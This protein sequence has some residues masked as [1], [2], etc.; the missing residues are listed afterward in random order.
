MKS[1]GKAVSRLLSWIIV[2]L[3]LLGLAM[4]FG[5]RPVKA[6]S[7]TLADL[8]L[9][10]PFNYRMEAFKPKFNLEDYQLFEK[11]FLHA[12]LFENR[13]IL[14]RSYFANYSKSFTLIDKRS[15]DFYTLHLQVLSYLVLEDKDKIESGIPFYL[16]FIQNSQ[17]QALAF[18]H[19]SE[20]Y[21]FPLYGVLCE[22]DGSLIKEWELSKKPNLSTYSYFTLYQELASDLT[23]SGMQAFNKPLSALF[24]AWM[25]GT[26]L[27]EQNIQTS[28][29]NPYTWDLLGVPKERDDLMAYCSEQYLM[30]E[31][32]YSWN[33]DDSLQALQCIQILFQDKRELSQTTFTFDRSY[34]VH[35][36]NETMVYLPLLQVVTRQGKGSSGAALSGL[37]DAQGRWNF[38]IQGNFYFSDQTYLRSPFLY[39]TLFSGYPASDSS[40][41][42]YL[43]TL[44]LALYQ[45][46]DSSCLPMIVLSHAIA[47]YEAN[48]YK[49]TAH[50]ADL[51]L[52]EQT[53]APV[54]RGKHAHLYPDAEVF[55]KQFAENTEVQSDTLEYSKED[56]DQLVHLFLNS[57]NK[58]DNELAS[59]DFTL[60]KS[61]RLLDQKTKQS[62]RFLP[63]FNLTVKFK[64]HSSF[65]FFSNSALQLPDKTWLIYTGY[66]SLCFKSG[67]VSDL[68]SWPSMSMYLS[69][70]YLS[71]LLHY[72]YLLRK[73]ITNE[74]LRDFTFLFGAMSWSK[75]DQ[76]TRVMPYP[77]L[78][79]TTLSSANMVVTA[80]P[81]KVQTGANYYIDMRLTKNLEKGEW[82]KIKFPKA[83]VFPS[84][85]GTKPPGDHLPEYMELDYENNIISLTLMKKLFIKEYED[86]WIRITI[87]DVYGFKNPHLSGAYYF[88]FSTSAEIEWQK[89]DSVLFVE[90]R[91]GVPEGIPEVNTVPSIAGQN[92][93]YTIAFNVGEGGW[94]KQGE[95]LIRLRFP[96]DT[97][98]T[99][100]QIPGEMIL[101]NGVPLSV[102]PSPRGQNLIFNTPVEVE[103]S[104][105]VVIQID[106]KAGIINPAQAGDYTIEVS[107]MPADPEWVASKAFTISQSFAMKVKPRK[108]GSSASY[109]FT[110]EIEK[111]LESSDWIKLGFPQ[112]TII[113]PPIPEQEPERTLRLKRFNEIIVIGLSPCGPC[114]TLPKI[115]YYPDGSM[116]SIQVY[117]PI[118]IDPSLPGY[119]IISIVCP[120]ECGFKTPAKE[121]FYEYRVST[122]RETKEIST[123]FEIVQSQIGVP[124]GVPQVMVDPPSA[125]TQAGYK[126]IFNVG[127]GGW[128]KAHRDFIRLRFPKGT[129]WAVSPDKFKP[130]WIKINGKPL[131]AN[132]NLSSE[133]LSLLVPMDIEDSERVVV[134][135]SEALGITNPPIAGEYQ[136]E[137]ATSADAWA[138]SEAYTI[139][140]E[141]EED[142]IKIVSFMIDPH[143]PYAHVISDYQIRIRFSDTLP[144]KEGDQVQI[145]LGHQGLFLTK[146]ISD[147]KDMKGLSLLLR[148]IPNPDPGEYTLK[149]TLLEE[150]ASYTYRILH[151]IPTSRIILEGGKKGKN[152]W[153]LEPPKIS[154]EVSDPEAK[155]VFWWNDDKPKPTNVSYQTQYPLPRVLDGGQFKAKLWY[156][157]YT[158]HGE[159]EPKFEEIWVDTVLPEI[160]IEQP[161]S[162]NLLTRE[163]ELEI[164]GRDTLVKTSIYGKEVLIYDTHLLK[165]NG[166][167]VDKDP[168]DGSFSHQLLLE[169][170]ANLILIEAEDEAGNRLTREYKVELDTTPPDIQIESPKAMQTVVNREKKVLIK[171]RLDDPGAELLIQGKIVD[172]AEDGQFEHAY[173]VS[174]GLNTISLMASDKVGNIQKKELQFWFGHTI[175]M[176]IGNKEASNNGIKKQLLLA[177]FIQNGRTLV[178]FRFIGEELGAR[179]DF[180]FHPT[181]RLVHTVSYQLEEDLIVLTIGSKTAQVNGKAVGL[182]V[183][184]Q[185]IQ[186]TT[187]VPIR[188]IAE[189]LGCEVL[190][191]APEQRISISYPR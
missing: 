165:I 88:E 132:A 188:F 3:I 139:T 42:H 10:L 150:S 131:S 102:R 168:N 181:S 95:A 116:K 35:H 146:T 184:P 27:S 162:Q 113:D 141:L 83:C 114:P 21:D 149:V 29:P 48:T 73:P 97:V 69:E 31:T 56:L 133:T 120:E 183:A 76:L 121:G 65:P 126:V 19:R 140:G 41:V 22:S 177:P 178:P 34:L 164:S 171:G 63:S 37:K 71:Y 55:A 109:N 89:S 62:Y 98:F 43:T 30:E 74:E 85:E 14:K 80:K 28:N 185:I 44:G 137:V 32:V 128:L 189:N 104:E 47:L 112:G 17:G 90:S 11:V 51:A 160:I 57:V 142:R 45:Q 82:I 186:G 1:F 153:W 110:F 130:E 7:S 118:K 100:N 72:S 46:I 66:G 145:D 50:T 127:R 61:F 180:T 175:L 173:I 151:P 94:L 75:F 152:N 148:K 38:W 13:Y 96:K 190:W 147:P 5:P 23:N 64:N 155:V 129:L 87:P 18:I 125:Y 79:K 122:Q 15:N 39:H 6:Q 191:S 91:I 93:S 9:D 60:H 108:I 25:W 106:A 163:K 40:Y 174:T 136:V 134:E 33:E 154:F 144:P 58:Q 117:T 16:S 119:N 161:S 172:I 81:R 135:I 8:Y 92:A 59:Y 167:L 12:S 54:P 24:S 20:M 182:D 2:A 49:D 70:I 86:G 77:S 53:M 169:E 156:Y 115:E 26:Y 166:V 158:G 99:Q 103:D 143:P 176:Q 138:K 159:E 67:F 36:P 179:I 101:V 78:K 170:G 111:T 52:E 4:P 123:S 107:T 157:A 105:R 187:V 68:A 84:Q 124:T